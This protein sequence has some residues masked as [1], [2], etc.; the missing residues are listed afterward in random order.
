MSLPTCFLKYRDDIN[1][2]QRQDVP[3]CRICKEATFI[4]LRQIQDAKIEGRKET[5]RE[6]WRFAQKDLVR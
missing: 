6:L 5:L 4:V 1:D 2:C 3:V